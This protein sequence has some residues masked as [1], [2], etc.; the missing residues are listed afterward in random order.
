ML[1]E[2]E[3]PAN[4]WGKLFILTKFEEKNYF[5][6]RIIANA[7]ST[8]IL[9]NGVPAATIDRG[10]FYEVD[11]FY[12][13]AIITTSK[14]ALVAQY[15]TSS[16]AD[17]VKA[18]DPF[19]L[20]AIPSDR[21]VKEVTSSSVTSGQYQH[22][23][24]VVVP[25]S[26]VN[27]FKIDGILMSSGTSVAGVIQYSKRSLAAAR[28]TIFSYRVPAGRHLMECSAPIAV[29]S[30]GFGLGDDNYDSYG[31]ACGMRLDK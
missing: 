12:H 9:I 16:N 6:A 18:G 20:L 7:D 15:C 2:M 19:M 24:N 5:V 3:P 31:H 30:Y 4:D 10:E 28:S 29:Y 1:L 11:T 21:F 23:L 13:D 26:A 17:T 14:P 22:F 25:D 8:E 27:S